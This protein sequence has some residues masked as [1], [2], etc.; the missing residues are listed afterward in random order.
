[1]DYGNK[2]VWISVNLITR[3]YI[4]VEEAVEIVCNDDSGNELIPELESRDSK[5]H[6]ITCGDDHISRTLLD[7]VSPNYASLFK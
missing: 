6:V 7:N 1:M 4:S 5:S 3:K 2:V